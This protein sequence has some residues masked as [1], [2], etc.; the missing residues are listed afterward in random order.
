MKLAVYQIGLGSFGRYGFEKFLEMH[1]HFEEV[2]IEFKGLCDTDFDKREKAERFA[3]SQGV[4]IEVYDK[5]ED[6]YSE[7]SELDQNVLI[8][9]AGPTDTHA[10]NIY[11][12][13]SHGFY[14]LAEKPPSMKR[15]QHLKE[16]ELAGKNSVM[17]TVDFIERE[18]PVVKKAKELLKGNE[19]ERIKIFRESSVGIE[20]LLDPAKRHGIKGGDILD[21]MIHEAYILDFL[22]IAGKDV[23]IEL[24]EAEARYF[25]PWKPGSQ[26][27]L[28][29]NGGYTEEISYETAT[30]Q[31]KALL[32][33]QDIEISL[34]SSWLGLSK[35]CRIEAKKAEEK[36]G[37]NVLD[38]EYSETSD[39]AFVNE[40]ARFFI[41]EGELN[42][43]GDM[44][45]KD[46]YDLDTGEK[47]ELDYYL[48]DQLYRVI[49]KAVLKASKNSKTHNSLS[50]DIDIFMNTIF[51]IKENVIEGEYLEELDNSLERFEGLVVIDRKVLETEEA[52]LILS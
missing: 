18:N 3:E 33:S 40:E 20:K 24:E 14:H 4:N 29:L 46:L 6:L 17:W 9:D 28:A 48:H 13:M 32:K 5:V 21:K 51:D 42:L 31:T 23:N 10:S 44:L 27:M 38:S 25:M 49:R 1:N 52:E 30:A 43:L 37:V 22:T 16:K 7:A 45:H 41:I 36:I 35:E 12:S 15:Q 11:R 26:K 39:S 47:I 2:D 34:N 8:Y 19:L 50:K